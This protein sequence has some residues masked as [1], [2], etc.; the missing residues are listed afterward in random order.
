MSLGELI[1]ELR[2]F[3]YVVVTK[4]FVNNLFILNRPSLSGTEVCND[5]R[6]LYVDEWTNS[7]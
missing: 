4:E 1:S 7:W 2:L 3:V 6:I 5:L